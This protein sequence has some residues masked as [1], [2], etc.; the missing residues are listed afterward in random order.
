VAIP[1]SERSPSSTRA[2]L[3][4]AVMGR[5]GAGKGTQCNRL[6]AELGLVHV[7]TGDL[8]R[9]A[10]SDGTALGRRVASIVESGA[11]VPDDIV[12]ELVLDRL[13]EADAEAQGFVLDGYPRTVAQAS[14]LMVSH[15]LHAVINLSV[16]S[17]VVLGRIG[18]R[19]VC[20][21][22]GTVTAAESLAEDFVACPN[23]D[24]LATR[25]ADDTEEAI[26]QRLALYDEQTHAVIEWY[27]AHGL[28]VTIDASNASDTVFE[29][30]VSA[31]APPL[32]SVR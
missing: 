28:L 3:R 5:Q 14:A 29:H 22:C 13:A 9:R 24:G 15:P 27:G 31:L 16:S 6:S 4:L 1:I 2:P 23:G 26:R 17:D 18:R 12:T 10:I 7:S 19:R 20:P 11:L 21:T 30:L 8:L 25:R 32:Q